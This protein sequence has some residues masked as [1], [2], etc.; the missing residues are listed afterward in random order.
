MESKR[1]NRAH[2]KNE[3]EKQGDTVSYETA[4]K[5]STF[6]GSFEYKACLK[7]QLTHFDNPHK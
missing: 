3:E 5:A 4:A 7:Q 6:S 2:E 1:S